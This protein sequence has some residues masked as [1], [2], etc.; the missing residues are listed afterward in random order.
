MC[1]IM[2]KFLHRKIF[3]LFFDRL[4]L[5]K[6]SLNLNEICR[7]QGGEF[8]RRR[9]NPKAKTDKKFILGKRLLIYRVKFCRTELSALLR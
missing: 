4:Y 2:P 7:Q 5:R 8:G 1:R 6:A 9:K 3:R